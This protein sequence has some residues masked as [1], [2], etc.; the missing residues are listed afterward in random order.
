MPLHILGPMVLI[1]IISIGIL[2]HLLGNSKRMVFT[3]ADQ[4]IDRWHREHPE[5]SVERV[6]ISDS[7][8][9]ALVK[10]D[11]GIGLIWVMGFDTASRIIA[12]PIETKNR[13]SGISIKLN[14]FTAPR[15]KVDL[16]TEQNQSHWIAILAAKEPSWTT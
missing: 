12:L 14:D 10:T 1:G 3:N 7:G 4:V 15:I 16:N 9:Q 13:Q 8:H 2:L 6:E 11:A 5:T